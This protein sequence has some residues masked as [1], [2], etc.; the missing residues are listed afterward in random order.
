MSDKDLRLQVILSAVD[1]LTRPFKAMQASNRTLASAVKSAKDQLKQLE[2]QSGPLQGFAKTKQQAAKAADALCTARDQASRL[3]LA[4]KGTD[5]PA[6]RQARQFQQ[7]RAAVT[8]LQ[9]RY[10]ALQA[11]LQQQRSAL[12]QSGIATRQ[13]AD[14][15]HTLKARTAEANTHLA[16][17]QQRLEQQAAQQKRLTNARRRYHQAVGVR[18]QLA[19]TGAAMAVTGGATLMG[20]KPA[21][22]EAALCDKERVEFLALGVGEKVVA[23]AQK[24]A[25]G[26]NIIGSSASDNLKILKEAHSVLRDYHEAKSV[27]PELLR[28]QFAT[29]FLSSHGVSEDAAQ[30]MRDQSPAVLK[31]AELRNMINDPDDFKKSVNLSAQALAAS[32]GMVLPDDYMAMLKTGGVAAKQMDDKAFYFAMSH[33]IQQVG[34]DR[35]GTS[36]SSAYQNLMMGRTT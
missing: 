24:Y 1:K 15:Q 20:L 27:T 2:R 31:I 34:G 16:T 11:S 26:L 5:A 4:M 19:G 6:A 32:G 36:L 12:Q 7:A 21:L 3:A 14:A 8:Q 18:N 9:S 17:Q 13:L 29:R 22:N 33:I 25:N 28:L 35:T 23:D 10:G 30:A